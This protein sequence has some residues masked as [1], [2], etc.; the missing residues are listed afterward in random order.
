MCCV[1]W[2]S[3]GAPFL[4]KQTQFENKYEEK[5]HTT[6]EAC[7]EVTSH[8]WVYGLVL[9]L[10]CKKLRRRRANAT[11]DEFILE[12]FLKFQG[13]EIK[14]DPYKGRN[15][16]PPSW[17]ENSPKFQSSYFA[18]FVLEKETSSRSQLRIWVT[19]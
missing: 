3:F 18:N 15:R 12:T 7:L 6:S 13:P 11:E 14:L 19:I 1:L 4:L 5:N 17:S 16:G 8:A 2:R 9:L 10:Q